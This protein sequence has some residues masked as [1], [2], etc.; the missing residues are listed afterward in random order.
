MDVLGTQLPHV[1]SSLSWIVPFCCEAASSPRFPGGRLHFSLLQTALGL[2]IALLPLSPAFPHFINTLTP[3]PWAVPPYLWIELQIWSRWCCFLKSASEICLQGTICRSI[4]PL[5]CSQ[6]F[7]LQDSWLSLLY[8]GCASLSALS[9]WDRI[10]SFA[11]AV[12]RLNCCFVITVSK[13][14]FALWA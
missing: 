7:S 3:V 4:C 6:E 14:L 5:G 9:Q 2:P 10:L 8:P 13:R 12:L 11:R 1:Q